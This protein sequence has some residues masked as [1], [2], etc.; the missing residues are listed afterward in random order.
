M[1][2]FVSA[3]RNFPSISPKFFSGIAFAIVSCERPKVQVMSEMLGNRYFIAGKF[4]LALRHLQAVVGESPGNARS[5]KK[6]VICCLAT[7][8]LNDALSHFCE[9]FEDAPAL[10]LAAE[11][12]E[13]LCPCEK[14]IRARTAALRDRQA[15]PNDYLTLGLLRAPHDLTLAL[16]N[17]RQAQ[18]MTD[19]FSLLSE[20]I[21]RLERWQKEHIGRH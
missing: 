21:P 17:L 19:E 4:E 5:R 20:L 8:K 9:L 11:L 10:A 6:L 14:L 3:Q 12:E 1:K 7:G 2:H 15:T 18:I 16:E 13:E